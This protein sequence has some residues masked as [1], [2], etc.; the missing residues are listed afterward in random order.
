MSP[1]AIRVLI[2]EDS[3]VFRE[4]LMSI[5]QTAPDLQVI[6]MACNGAEAVRLAKRLE[7]DVITM[8]IYMPEMDGFEATRQI[9]TE[10]PRPIVVISSGVE[11]NERD[12]TFS[13]LKAGA[14]AVMP[15]PTVFDSP[16]VHRALAHQVKLMAEVKVVRHWGR[17]RPSATRPLKHTD[18]I[19]QAS[20]SGKVGLVAV[21]AST[22]GPGVLAEILGALPVN[23]S[24]P[25]LVVQHITPGFSQGLADWLNQQTPLAVSLAHVGQVPQPGQVLIAPDHAHL[26]VDGRGVVLIKN[27]GQEYGVCPAADVL[28]D[29]VA[30]HFGSKAI[31]VILTG[32]GSDGAEGLKAMRDRGAH[33]IAQDEQSCVVFGMPGVAIQLG[34]A[35]QVLPANRIAAAIKALV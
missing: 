34:A 18:P 2:A 32:M 10:T 26:S 8:D 27:D 23:F 24:V 16:E 28:F 33:T 19:L 15:K 20:D 29:G 6:G 13:A 7:P 3:P 14:L 1:S 17:E 35:E 22:G 31:G 11:K 4:L 9:M 5:L 21:A 30:Q 25:I 12:L